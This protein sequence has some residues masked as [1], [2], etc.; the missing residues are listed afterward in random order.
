MLWLADAEYE[1][2]MINQIVRNGFLDGMILSSIHL[3]D[4]IV[5]CHLSILRCRLSLLDSLPHN[6]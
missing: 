3:P 6:G 5:R 4:E 1:R 2:R